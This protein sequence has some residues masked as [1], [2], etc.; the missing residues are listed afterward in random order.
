M[1]RIRLIGFASRGKRNADKTISAKI[2]RLK[3]AK[4][5]R[6]FFETKALT[7]DYARIFVKNLVSEERKK[8][9]KGK[10]ISLPRALNTRQIAL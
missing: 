6:N 9:C 5:K 2:S 8:N 10:L 4:R 3:D 1:F 7:P